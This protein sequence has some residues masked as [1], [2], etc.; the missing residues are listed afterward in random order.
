MCCMDR[1]YKVTMLKTKTTPHFMDDGNV[2]MW[3][4][5]NFKVDG[6]G[7]FSFV[8]SPADELAG[9]AQEK[10]RERVQLIRTLHTAV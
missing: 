9:K 8:I 5:Y 7:P 3:T 6:D 4:M 1:E 2:E 10:I